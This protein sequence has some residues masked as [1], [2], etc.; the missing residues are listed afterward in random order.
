LRHTNHPTRKEPQQC[1][2]QQRLESHLVLCV[3]SKGVWGGG[4]LKTTT[5]AVWSSNTSV[6]Q[7]RFRTEQA[8]PRIPIYGHTAM[9]AADH[10][11]EQIRPVPTTLRRKGCSAWTLAQIK[12]SPELVC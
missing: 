1:R 3:G 5:A 2:E 9:A 4:G 12:A 7:P 6:D 11:A 10:E 8:N